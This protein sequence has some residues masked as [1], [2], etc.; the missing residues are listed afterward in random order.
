MADQHNQNIPAVGNQISSDIPDIK[1]NLEYHKDVMQNFLNTWSDTTA[2]S[3]FPVKMADADEDTLYQL[4]ESSDEDTHR[5]DV[6]GTE[7]MT[8]EATNG[9]SIDTISEKT[10]ANGVAID[11]LGIKD[12]ALTTNDSVPLNCLVDYSTVVFHHAAEHTFTDTGSLTDQALKGAFTMPTG[13]TALRAHINLKAS[14]AGLT[15]YADF[16]V[17]LASTG[18]AQA[19][20]SDV[21]V[22]GTTASWELT[23]AL[24]ISG[25]T[26]GTVYEI[27]IR[28]YMSGAGTGTFGGI[29]IH[30]Y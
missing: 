29:T 30:M 11:G 22:T 7:M 28:A 23:D 8:L 17:N 21:S 10:A 6:A 26:P 20:S 2:S 4:E 15:A 13:A 24:D 12:A 3:S 5:W 19:N 14:G 25:L 1:E 27:V 18:V 16:E 9:L